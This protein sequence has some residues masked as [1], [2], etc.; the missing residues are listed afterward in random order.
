MV[1]SRRRIPAR[2]PLRSTL[3]QTPVY[4]GACFDAT[5]RAG[6]S[7]RDFACAGRAIAFAYSADKRTFCYPA[8]SCRVMLEPHHAHAVLPSHSILW[9]PFAVCKPVSYLPSPAF[10]QSCSSYSPLALPSLIVKCSSSRRRSAV[11][12]SLV[13]LFAWHQPSQ[14]M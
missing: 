6:I 3:Y 7:F 8:G 14:D 5:L 9:C 2:R 10:L 11:S 1:V 13:H 12:S 4:I